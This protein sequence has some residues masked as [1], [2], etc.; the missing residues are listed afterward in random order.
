[1]KV[2]AFLNA[3]QPYEWEPSN[4]QLAASLGLRLEQ[5]H[6]FDTN[7]SPFRPVKWLEE[8]AKLLPRLNVNEYPDPSYS[9]VRGLLAE[10]VGVDVDQI[11]LANGGDEA[12][13]I[14]VRAFIDPGTKALISTPTYS[15]F[16][17]LV[18]V[19]GGEALSVPRRR[20]FTDDVD[21]IIS[22]IGDETRLIFLCSPNNPTGNIVKRE[23]V[24]RILEEPGCTVVID[25]A[26]YEF[27]GKTLADLTSR[28]ENLIVIR[29]F[30]KA[31]SLAG[32]RLGYIVASQKTTRLLN[33]LRPPN[34][35]GIISLALA[36]IALKDLD[37]M[38][39]YVD[40]ILKERDRCVRFLQKLKNV[41]VYPSEA[42]F[43]LLRFLNLKGERA[44]RLLLERGLVT[45]DF[46]KVPGLEG[47]IRFSPARP[48][49]NDM[50]LQA[51]AEI[52][53]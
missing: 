29:T 7:T 24:L 43:L 38:R 48:E 8:L 4:E 30:S 47:C 32:V 34:S 15:L 22:H 44:H 50:L 46:S 9:K 23:D 10:Y 1:M 51:I 35:V 14:I 39:G 6:R 20:N 40:N 21:A 37:T 18:E 52:A 5:I 11:L 41:V 42:N 33:K 13:D 3:F 16:K 12:L 27:S 17:I 36:E 45:R 31:F 19:M 25:E 53:G 26:Y 2:R 28:Y 49:E